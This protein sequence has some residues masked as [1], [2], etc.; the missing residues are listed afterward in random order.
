MLTEAQLEAI[1]LK[2][3]ITTKIC[4]D[5]EL[6]IEIIKK[7]LTLEQNKTE[8]EKADGFFR[9]VLDILRVSEKKVLENINLHEI[10]VE[11]C[12][13]EELGNFYFNFLNFMVNDDANS[14]LSDRLAELLKVNRILIP[15]SSSI[16]RLYL[17]Q[18]LSIALSC[19]PLD[20]ALINELNDELKDLNDLINSGDKK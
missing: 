16:K 14:D 10:F 18:T 4:L 9:M 11:L 1:N 7:F 3:Q 19:H 5:E 2:A 12:E 17:Y 20:I 6:D 15:V 8:I 13:N